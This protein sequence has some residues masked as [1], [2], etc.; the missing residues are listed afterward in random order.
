MRLS[1]SD[2]R[3]PACLRGCRELVCFDTLHARRLVWRIL[4]ANHLW[5]RGAGR[6]AR[7]VCRGGRGARAGEVRLLRVCTSKECTKQGP[8]NH[9]IFQHSTVDCPAPYLH[10]LFSTHSS[11]DKLQISVQSSHSQ[12][13]GSPPLPIK[14]SGLRFPST[15]LSPCLL[16]LAPPRPPSPSPSPSSSPSSSSPTT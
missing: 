2:P 10:P 7:V 15:A 4:L 16:P 13:S 1:E 5:T 12:S 6:A 8:G 9:G 14:G 3:T 11:S